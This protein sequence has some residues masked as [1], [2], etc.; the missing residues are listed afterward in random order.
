MTTTLTQQQQ[1]AQQRRNLAIKS[2][3]DEIDNIP[4]ATQQQINSNN[5]ILIEKEELKDLMT[6]MFQQA[7][8]EVQ[9]SLEDSFKESLSKKSLSN[10]QTQLNTLQESME[11]LQEETKMTF[12]EVTNC[13]N[14][15]DELA[16]WLNEKGW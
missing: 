11:T 12:Q 16:E 9:K 15:L 14:Q 2:I 7:L 5:Y 3:L 10:L 13:Q 1:A 4:K 8:K 6:L